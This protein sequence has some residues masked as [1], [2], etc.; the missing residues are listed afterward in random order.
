MSSS[1]GWQRATAV[2]FRRGSLDQCATS[3]RSANLLGVRIS[4]SKRSSIRLKKAPA[5]SRGLKLQKRDISS[6]ELSFGT[7]LFSLARREKLRSSQASISRAQDGLLR[8]SS[9]P[10]GRPL[11]FHG[12]LSSTGKVRNQLQ[13]MPKRLEFQWSEEGPSGTILEWA[14]RGKTV[15]LT[16]PRI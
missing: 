2:L 15:Q 6:T 12:W 8:F 9:S 13:R 1:P 14:N 16:L 10:E 7:G 5:Y 3:S 4:P 11:C